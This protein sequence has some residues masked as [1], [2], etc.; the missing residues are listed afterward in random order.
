[1]PSI[2]PPPPPRRQQRP[3]RRLWGGVGGGGGEDYLAWTLRE[4]DEAPVSLFA[5]VDVLDL[6]PRGE[7]LFAGTLEGY[8]CKVNAIKEHLAR[9]LRDKLSSCKVSRVLLCAHGRTT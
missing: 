1:V 7:A 4:V 8:D 2:W 3:P 6:S 5:T 9:L